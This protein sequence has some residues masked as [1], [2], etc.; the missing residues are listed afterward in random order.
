MCDGAP[1][2][3]PSGPPPS[4][5]TGPTINIGSYQYPTAVA[6]QKNS[7][8][9]LVQ[10]PSIR[11]NGSGVGVTVRGYSTVSVKGVEVVHSSQGVIV[12]GKSNTNSGN[13]TVDDCVFRG[14]WNRSSIGQT[15]PKAGRDCTNGWSP[16]VIVGNFQNAA[17]SHCLFDDIDVAFQPGGS[18]GSMDFNSNTISRANGNTVMMVGD[19]EW[20][21]RSNVFSRDNAARFFMCGTTDIMI[22][23]ASLFFSFFFLQQHQYTSTSSTT[24][25]SYFM[26]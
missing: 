15:V 24:C 5:S 9:E 25:R 6:N 20:Q 14:V 1:C 13:V 18:L 12:S 21:V 23:T 3:C 2:T 10:R 4:G 26:F 22:G 8:V 16:S 7:P 19:T 17:V 11:L